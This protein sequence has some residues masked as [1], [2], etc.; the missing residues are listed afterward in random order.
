MSGWVKL[1]RAVMDKPIW[2]ESTSD[3]K[4]IL[5]ALLML[6]N[7]EERQWKWGG[8]EYDLQPGQFVTSI[9]SLSQR[10]GKGVTVSKVRTALK[11]FEEYG[12]MTSETTNQNQVITIV[13]WG[14]YQKNEEPMTSNFANERRACNKQIATTKKERTKNIRKNARVNEFTLDLTKG[15]AM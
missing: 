15:E 3:Q 11:R 12:F 7:Y 10:C 14:L 13:N 4:V 8:R 9:A 5:M 6:A 1:H 2:T